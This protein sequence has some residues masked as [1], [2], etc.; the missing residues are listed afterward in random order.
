MWE[1]FVVKGLGNNKSRNSSSRMI[2]KIGVINYFAIK[3]HRK[4]PVLGSLV[5]KVT[6]LK[7]CNFI[8]KETPANVFL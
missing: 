2:F 8:K 4:R 6:G 3:V 1:I 7:T 5:N